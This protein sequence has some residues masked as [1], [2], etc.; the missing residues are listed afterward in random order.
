MLQC[1]ECPEFTK[2]PLGSA[3]Q[4]QCVAQY[5]ELH[6]DLVL[7][8]GYCTGTAPVG[9]GEQVEEV[10]YKPIT[11]ADRCKEFVDE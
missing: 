6:T 1:T 3:S 10:D 2:S 4:E 7:A 11:T 8:R 9:E 5:R